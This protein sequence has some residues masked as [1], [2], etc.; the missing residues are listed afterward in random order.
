MHF[1]SEASKYTLLDTWKPFIKLN[2]LEKDK[3]AVSSG[4]KN[5]FEL[6]KLAENK[7]VFKPI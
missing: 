6:R 4:E 5:V 7:G 1:I 2:R 3:H